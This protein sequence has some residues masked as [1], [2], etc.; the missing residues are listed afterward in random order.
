MRRLPGVVLLAGASLVAPAFAGPL[1]FVDATPESG[2]RF[3][4]LCGAPAGEKGWLSETMGAGAAWLDY[5]GDGNLD[6]YL[7]NGSTYDRKPGAGEANKLYRGD[8][9][10]RCGKNRHAGPTGA[11]HYD[12]T[13]KR[14]AYQFERTGHQGVFVV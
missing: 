14:I 12:E 9:K 1:R 8:G 4:N 7:V 3:R 5:D 2:I 6:L 13:S 11:E 10:G